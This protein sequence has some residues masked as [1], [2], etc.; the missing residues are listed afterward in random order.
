MGLGRHSIKTRELV[1]EGTSGIEAQRGA[2][3]LAMTDAAALAD[4]SEEFLSENFALYT[5]ND[6]HTERVEWV[7]PNKHAQKGNN[8]V[9]VPS[10]GCYASCS[11]IAVRARTKP[12]KAEVATKEVGSI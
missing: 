10:L 6:G 1:L 2:P 4:N 8:T 12:G 9:F 3:A 11:Q 5:H 7:N